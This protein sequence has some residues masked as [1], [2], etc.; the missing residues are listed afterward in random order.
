MDLQLLK[1]PHIRFLKPFIYGEEVGGP[2]KK[3]KAVK[4]LT[5][6]HKKK[7]TNTKAS[8]T[9]S[10]ASDEAKQDGR[11][12]KEER[13]RANYCSFAF[14]SICYGCINGGLALALTRSN[15]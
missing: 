4:G 11:L 7:Q 13:R 6:Q 2:T 12:G 9:N 5:N 10:K 8:Y 14:G 1:P 15:D 3:T